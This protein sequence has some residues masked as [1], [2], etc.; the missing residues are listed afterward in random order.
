MPNLLQYQ[1]Q[2]LEYL[3][4]D[5]SLH[6]P[7]IDKCLGLY[8]VIYD[9]YVTDALI[10]LTQS[11]TFQCITQHKSQTAINTVHTQITEWLKRHNQKLD[12]LDALFISK[13]LYENSTS[14]YAQ[15]KTVT[16][17]HALLLQRLPITCKDSAN[18]SIRCFSQLLNPCLHNQRLL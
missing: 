4:N 7:E 14:P 10:H 17:P 2:M 16:G 3:L 5:P 11:N 12:K 18:G 8:V 1:E 13:N 9:I 6:F 15:F